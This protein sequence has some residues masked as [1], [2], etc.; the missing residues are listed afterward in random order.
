MALQDGSVYSGWKEI[1]T[2]LNS[3]LAPALLLLASCFSLGATTIITVTGAGKGQDRVPIL[4]DHGTTLNRSFAGE[5]LVTINGQNYIAYCV[6]FFTEIGTG[7]YN[8][9]FLSPASYLNGARA[10]WIYEMN[11]FASVTNATAAAI[12]LAIW[13]V[14]HDGGDGLN[15]GNIRLS[16]SGS[17]SLRT[18]AEALIN[19]SAG[20][21]SVNE[22]ILQNM[23]FN[24]AP[25]QWLI[26][27]GKLYPN[28]A[29]PEPATWTMI[30]GGLG[31]CAWKRRRYSGGMVRKACSSA[32]VKK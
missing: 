32:S 24:G 28:S 7:T 1:M 19:A 29:V 25:A 14:I 27:A 16:S 22:T 4:T 10:A 5:I 30:A 26:T 6:D 20:H 17:S 31:L 11:A 13:D 9:T 15:A 18:A 12:Q 2:L 8:S 23:A 21:T 3:Y